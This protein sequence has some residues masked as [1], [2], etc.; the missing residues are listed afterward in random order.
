MRI[1]L[2]YFASLREAL[3]TATESLELPEAVTTVDGVREHLSARGPD[4]ARALGDGRV[5][6]VALDQIIAEPDSPIHDGAEVAFFPPV[7]GG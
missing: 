3:G 7:T 5:I 4:W 2:L 1:K 6:R